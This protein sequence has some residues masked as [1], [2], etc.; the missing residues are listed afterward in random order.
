MC[1]IVGTN[2]REPRI[3]ESVEILKHRGPDAKGVKHFTKA[4]LGHTR[5]SILDLSNNGKQPMSNEDGSLWIVFNGEIYNYQELKVNLEKRHIFTS[6][7]DT[8]V[9]LHAYED[10]GAECVQYLNGMFSFAIYDKNKNEWFIARDRL[11]IKP[12]YYYYRNKKLVF[13]SEIKAITPLVEDLEISHKAISAYLSFLY[14]PAPMTIFKQIKKLPPG[15]VLKMKDKKKPRVIKYWELKQTDKYASISHAEKRVI[16]LLDESVRQRLLADVPVGAFLSG[17]VDSTAVVAFMRKYI[18]DLK[19][20]S[21]SF[22]K[23]EYDESKYAKMASDSFQTEHHVLYF[24]HKDVEKNFEKL[25]YHYDEP[26]GD[27]SMIP[28][29]LVSKLARKHVTV[30]L[31]GDGADELFGGYNTYK[32]FKLSGW[33]RWVPFT[34]LWTRL[35]GLIP[36]Y[37]IKYFMKAVRI[38]NDRERYYYFL[39]HFNDKEKK[40]LMLLAPEDP[41]ERHD[42]HFN[43]NDK[44]KSAMNTDIHTYLQDDILVKLDKASMACSLEG[45]VPFLDHRLVEFSQT[46][47]PKQKLFGIKTKHFLK[48]ALKGHI[49][50]EILE[51]EK[52]GF[53]LPLADWLRNELNEMMRS[54]LLN[55]SIKKPKVF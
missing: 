21:V 35:V 31:S 26:Y 32:W 3:K 46:I 49:P 54:L 25:V 55:D 50:D 45:R 51:R 42:E 28:T 39:T 37:K 18:H 16:D 13:S 2:Y 53:S 15:C 20:F 27:S 23:P 7:T 38:K 34:R 43:S 33:C 36:N 8:E 12:L 6:N 11:G 19:T 17:G 1:G 5:L 14:I 10:W 30:S 22:D 24:N 48:G 9:I 52:K 40:K 44:I 41:Y 4:S 29:Y 47:D